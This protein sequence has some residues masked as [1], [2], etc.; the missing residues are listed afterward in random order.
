MRK[1][2]AEEAISDWCDKIEQRG[3][4]EAVYQVEKAKKR[5]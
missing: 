1:A 2:A 3:I 4:A 5:S